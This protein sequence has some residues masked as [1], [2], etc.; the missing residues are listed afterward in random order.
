[1]TA[2]VSAVIPNWNRCDLLERLLVQLNAQSCAFARVIVVDNGSTDG[3]ADLAEA[4]G[5]AVIRLETNR[6][7]APA[8]NKGIEQADTEWVAILNNDV[9]L[10]PDWLEKLL[11]GAQREQAWFASGKL[12]A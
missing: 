9:E 1:M 4:L 10:P 3:S 5:A 6:G 7:F 2:S 12:L 8:V 11:A